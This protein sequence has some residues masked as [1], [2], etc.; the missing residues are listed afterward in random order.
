MTADLNIF[1]FI[2]HLTGSTMGNVVQRM[3]VSLGERGDRLTRAEDKTVE[4][5]HKAHQFADTAHKVARQWPLICIGFGCKF[6]EMYLMCYVS[7]S[8]PWSIPS[9]VWEETDFDEVWSNTGADSP[10][11]PHRDEGSVAT[12]LFDFINETKFGI[13]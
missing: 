9:R 6:P 3:N 8:W 11:T 2:C 7:R 5:M 13:Y 10:W 4:L 12:K 1:L